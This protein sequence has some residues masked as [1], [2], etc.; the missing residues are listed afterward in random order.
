GLPARFE[1]GF[2]LPTDK[3]AG[4]IAGYHC[5]AWFYANDRGWIPVDI[6]EA[7][8]HPRLKEYYF[9]NLTAD[10]VTFSVGRDLQLDPPAKHEPLN[11]MVYPHI[12][13]GGEK[14]PAT[15]IELQFAYENLP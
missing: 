7:D 10:R 6:S 14:L 4:P 1:I 3:P 15:N 5:W 12:E 9:G 2:S 8:K 11:F 13:V